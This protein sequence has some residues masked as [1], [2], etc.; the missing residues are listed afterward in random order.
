MADSSRTEQ[1]IQ[2]LQQWAQRT[3]SEKSHKW[4]EQ[5]V[6]KIKQG[7]KKTLFLSFGLASRKVAK[8]D[9][10][11]QIEDLSAAKILRENWNPSDWTLDQIVRSIFV[12][13][14]PSENPDEYLTTLDQLFASGEVR[15]LVTLYQM[16]P[17]LPHSELHA[18]R[19]AEGVRTNMKSVF[20]A[21]AHNNPYPSE[22][23][24]ES[25]WNQMVLKCLFIDVPLWP[26]VGL[27]TRANANLSKML[28]DYAHERWA[29]SRVVSPELWRC[30]G[31]NA[32]ESAIADLN[33][34]IS[35]GT[36]VE[37]KAAAMSLCTSQRPEAITIMNEHSNIKKMIQ[38]G[39]LDWNT[40]SQNLN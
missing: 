26:I 12:L 16:L 8:D 39:D 3:L 33:K 7:D 27:D 38:D 40:F 20:C 29:A 22:Q 24:D 25:S 11:L 14:F 28:C 10:N 35:K 32:D 21:V 17:I 15:E 18:L 2:I 5:K 31:P 6:E 4:V 37:Q 1:I 9:L 23:F 13:S 30:V 36:E 19:A 34:V